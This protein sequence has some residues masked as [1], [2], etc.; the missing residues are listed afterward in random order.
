MTKW[1]NKAEQHIEK[2][3]LWGL[4]PAAAPGT[5][6]YPDAG[7]DLCRNVVCCCC[8]V[9]PARKTL[10]DVL[11][12]C[13]PETETPFSSYCHLKEMSTSI[14]ESQVSKKLSAV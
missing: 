9:P 5:G 7:R 2:W 4:T 13:V 1:F 11:Q 12:V 8:S 3:W 10:L 6:L 14:E